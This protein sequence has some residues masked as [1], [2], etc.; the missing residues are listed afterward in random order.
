[1]IIFTSHKSRALS[2]FGF[3]DT[4]PME[5]PIKFLLSVC[6]SI[7]PSTCP[8][9]VWYFYQELVVSFLQI[10]CTVVDNWNIKKL[11]EPFFPGKFIFLQIWGKIAQG[12]PK[13]WGF[14][15][16]L[17][18][19]VISFPGNNLKRKLKLLFILHHQSHS[20]QNSGSRVMN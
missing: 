11:A 18:K 14:F 8:S 2:K 19:F 15:Y 13:I 12:D 16:F 3:L 1:M 7:C 6:L 20:W 9:A 17:K 5:F 4:C 10:F